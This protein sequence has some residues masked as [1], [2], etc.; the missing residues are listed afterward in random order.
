MALFPPGKGGGEAV[1]YGYKGKGITNHLLIEG[2]GLPLALVA[3]SAA[4]S[5]RDQVSVLLGRVRVY[6]GYGRPKKCPH[7]IHA[8]RG[9]D[10]KA[11]RIFLRNKGLRPVI[12]KR[13]WKNRKQSR[14]RKIPPS[15]F[16]WKVER[17]FS[18]L[19]R[20]FRRL[21]VRWERRLRYWEGFLQLSVVML[22]VDKM[23]SG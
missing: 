18:W 17:C 5:E 3:T 22:W 8:D 15:T 12:S 7:E 14:G 4:S 9:Y 11:L 16:R 1:D 23:I 21:T 6:K 19:Q 2:N 20:R 13:V 10:S